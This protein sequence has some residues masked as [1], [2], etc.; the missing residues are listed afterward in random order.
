[1]VG[2]VQRAEAA[3]RSL[4]IRERVK[5]ERA[6]WGDWLHGRCRLVWTRTF[7]FAGME[8]PLPRWDSE[9]VPEPELVS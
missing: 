8:Y 3:G 4:V 5:L 7:P 9:R 6:L 1:M 2:V